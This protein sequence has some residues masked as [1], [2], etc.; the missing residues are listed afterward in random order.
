M[1]D[2]PLENKNFYK[3]IIKLK[4]ENFNSVINDLE[5]EREKLKNNSLLLKIMPKTKGSSFCN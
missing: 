1:N 5:K 2:V 4:D 3:N